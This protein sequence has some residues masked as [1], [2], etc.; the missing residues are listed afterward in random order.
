MPSR[1]VALKFIKCPWCVWAHILG[2]L[3]SLFMSFYA[4]EP[5]FPHLKIK[6]YTSDELKTDNFL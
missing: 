1:D 3:F 2:L 6:I 4:S 5:Q